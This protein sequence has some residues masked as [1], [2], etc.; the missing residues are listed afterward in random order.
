ML[1]WIV[2][3]A[4][5]LTVLLPL[6]V[7]AEPV[8]ITGTVV[9]ADGNPVE[10]AKVWLMEAAHMKMPVAPVTTNKE[11]EFSITLRYVGQVYNR[12]TQAYRPVGLAVYAQGPDGQRAAA[13]VVPPDATE[14]IVTLGEAGFLEA[15]VEDRD[16]NPVV[17]MDAVV[18]LDLRERMFYAPP[19]RF[20]SDEAGLLRIGPVPAGMDFGI[21]EG[22]TAEP[23]LLHTWP[24]QEMTPIAPG[25]TRKLPTMRVNMAGRKLEGV[26]LNTD[27]DPVAGATV[28]T[29]DI[30]RGDLMQGTGLLQIRT[31]D[32]G[33][34]ELSGLKT[35]GVIGVVAIADD[36]TAACGGIFD[37]DVGLDATLQLEPFAAL[38]GVVTDAEGQACA[39]VRVT[40]SSHEVG[41]STCQVGDAPKSLSVHV[42]E[43]L[44][45]QVETDED[46]RWRI[47]RL[48]SGL[49]YWVSARDGQRRSGSEDIVLTGLQVNEI[50]LVIR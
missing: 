8:T 32:E 38:T 44:L 19:V 29:T 31:D 26:V 35:A 49:Q 45:A 24:E 41:V 15:R 7:L 20:A 13:Q 23:V 17:S 40:A 9:D 34:F 39:G 30:V 18:L 27:G 42:T 1:R 3:V 22:W 37:P 2:L 43:G 47:E 28:M 14:V 25:E 21:R 11:G 48:I 5:A 36:A 46:G 10:G 4:L 12:T 33:R 6:S 16:G 50:A